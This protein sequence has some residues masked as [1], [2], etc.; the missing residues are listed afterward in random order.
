MKRFFCTVCKKVKRVQQWPI[1]VQAYSSVNVYDRM[2]TCNRHSEPKVY[3]VKVEK[4][5]THVGA[6]LIK[7]DRAKMNRKGK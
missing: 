2:G 4:T 5:P 1:D 7:Q 3:K 6:S